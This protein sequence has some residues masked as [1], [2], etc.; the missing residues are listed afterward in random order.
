M[1]NEFQMFMMGELTFFLRYSRQANKE[2]Y[3]STSSQVHEGSDE[4]VQHS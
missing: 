3:I 4:E 2:R 1:Y